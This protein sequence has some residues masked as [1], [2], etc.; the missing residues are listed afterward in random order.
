MCR[1]S[2][3]REVAPGGI[4]LMAGLAI[5]NLV[6]AA[7]WYEQPLGVEVRGMGKFDL[8]GIGRNFQR[9]MSVP[10]ESSNIGRRAAEF[11]ETSR[12][13]S[14]ASSAMTVRYPD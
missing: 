13:I 11:R 8:S 6:R 10:R 9:R 2:N 5:E 12:H 14:M 1:V 7:V 3:G 4:V